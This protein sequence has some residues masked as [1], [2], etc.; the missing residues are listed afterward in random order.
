MDVE[1]GVGEG[2]EW[3]SVKAQICQSFKANGGFFGRCALGW[4]M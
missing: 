3:L 1:R 2:M 4:E